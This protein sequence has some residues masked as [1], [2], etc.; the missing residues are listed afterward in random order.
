MSEDTLIKKISDDAAAAVADITAT[1]KA[2][3]AAI[4]AETATLLEA[5]QKMHDA[6]LQKE[7][8]HL[9]TVTLSKARQTANI[10]V[11]AAKRQGVDM[12]FESVFTD[13]KDAEADAYVALFTKV[14][15]SVVPEKTSGT[16]FCPVGREDETKKILSAVHADAKIEADKSISAGFI[17]DTVDGVFDVSLDRLFGELRPKLEMEIIAKAI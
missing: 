1:S 8:A 16:A 2:D 4:E 3:I 17:L 6:A 11:Q 13:L 7:K 9:E 5:N 14:A 10:A 15:A 12:I